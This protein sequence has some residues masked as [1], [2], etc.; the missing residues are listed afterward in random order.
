MAATVGAAPAAAQTRS[1]FKLDEVQATLAVQ[2]VQGW[3][4]V[5][6]G[7]RNPVALE[8]VNPAGAPTKA[9]FY[10]IPDKGQPSAL[11]HEDDADSF[12]GVMGTMTTYRSAGE[13]D[14]AIGQML[15]GLSRVAMEYAPQSGIAALTRVDDATVKQIER[16]KTEVV[17]SANLV[18]FTKSLWGPDGRVAHYIVAHH[19]DASRKLA[20]AF[21][22]SELRAGRAITEL[23]VQEHLL[24]SYAV[25][26]ISGDPPAVAAGPN[27][28]R[29]DYVPSRGSARTIAEGDLLR[30]TLW[31]RLDDSPRPIYA[32]V[33]WMAYAGDA[34]PQRYRD[35]FAVTVA[36]RDA[37][38]AL[39]R[40]RLD[41]RRNVQ[42]FQADR[43]AREVVN[44]A[45]LGS[46]FKHRTGHSLDTSVVGDGANLDDYESHDTRAL[47]RGSGF[48]VEPGVY[49]EDFGVKTEIDVFLGQRGVEITTQAQTEI[50][51][52][53]RAGS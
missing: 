16:L 53:L 52:L 36:A 49:F 26:G 44:R 11:V 20:L 23:D 19:L 35:A 38:V 3:L 42:G 10:L 21:V 47:V 9:W 43:A 29:P 12:A 41:R 30:L 45:G 40:D 34:V 15:K 39:I 7:D 50:Q 33:T 31:A 25:R 8:L 14:R 46:R 13:R 5:G 32:N 17:S 27:T 22:A 4:L 51:P 1:R 24:R 37:V 18:Q 48:T 28:A 2:G 6:V